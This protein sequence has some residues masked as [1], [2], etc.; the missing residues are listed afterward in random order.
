MLP[1]EDA[2]AG[3]A[4]RSERALGCSIGALSRG[5]DRVGGGGAGLEDA[6]AGALVTTGARRMGEEGVAGRAGSTFGASGVITP[7]DSVTAPAG[8]PGVAGAMTSAGA[9]GASTAAWFWRTAR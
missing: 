6:R 7:S 3:S 8:V 5:A 1:V 4:G 9:I 2:L